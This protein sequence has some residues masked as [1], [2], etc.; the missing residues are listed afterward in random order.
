VQV[1][2]Q[3]QA[4]ALVD[5]ALSELSKRGI[6]T[7]SAFFPSPSADCGAGNFE[8]RVAIEEHNDLHR[9]ETARFYKGKEMTITTRASKR[10]HNPARYYLF[11]VLL[12]QHFLKE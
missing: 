3:T 9:G 11:Y 2:N 8:V 1:L 6:Y 7:I 12:F 10:T 4:V 5:W